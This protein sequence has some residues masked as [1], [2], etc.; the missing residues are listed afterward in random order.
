MK[1]E[2]KMSVIKVQYD[3]Y[4]RQFKFVEPSPTRPLEDG[5]TYLL[6][7]EDQPDDANDKESSK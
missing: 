6:L 1:E 3:A 7:S 5:G 2:S 4:N